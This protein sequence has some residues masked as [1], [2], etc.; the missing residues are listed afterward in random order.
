[1]MKTPGRGIWG[2]KLLQGDGTLGTLRKVAGIKDGQ[3]ELSSLL[4]API[5]W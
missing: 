2:G 1:M 3:V 4:C 5:K